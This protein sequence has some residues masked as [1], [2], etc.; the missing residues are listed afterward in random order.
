MSFPTRNW[1]RHAA[2]ET[3]AP[4]AATEAPAPVTPASA[5]LDNPLVMGLGAAVVV[6]GVALIAVL[7]KR[8]K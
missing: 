2:A 6:L 4:A 1:K 5:G 8:K 7:L 3:P